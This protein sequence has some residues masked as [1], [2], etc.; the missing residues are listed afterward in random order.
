MD[1]DQL[2]DRGAEELPVGPEGAKAHV[3]GRVDAEL[4]EVLEEGVVAA[5]DGTVVVVEDD[6]E[7]VA[8]GG[9]DLALEG[10]EKRE[11]DKHQ[12]KGGFIRRNT[13]CE[14]E[15]TEICYVIILSKNQDLGF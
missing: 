12:E 11:E 4:R 15:V 3:L 9:T 1:V 13:K 6:S 14:N 8:G 2:R 7:S 10:G 5:V